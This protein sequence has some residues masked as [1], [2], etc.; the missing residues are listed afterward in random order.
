MPTDPTPLLERVQILL[1]DA[2]GNLF[3]SE[4]P[5]FDASVEVTNAFLAEIGSDRRFTADELR[6]EATG[7]NFRTTALRLTAAEGVTDIDVDPWVAEEKR[8]VTAHLGHTLRPHLPTSAALTDLAAVLPLAAVSSSALARLAACF[9][10]TGLDDLIPPARRYSA[11]DSLPTPTSKPDPAV[12]LHACAQL[13]IAPEAGLAV[14]DAVAGVRSAVA[15]GCPT[16]GNLLFVLPDERADRAE[17]LRAAGALAVVSSW[18]ELADLLLPV[19][20]RRG[21]AADDLVTGAAR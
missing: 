14:E 10:A 16:I 17:A 11:E 12:Y 18:Q 1:C 20:A 15:A 7:M 6:H 19:L 3:P 13:G 2:D 5:A 8:A 4:E 9:T 21:S